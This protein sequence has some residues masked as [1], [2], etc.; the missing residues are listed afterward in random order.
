MVETK[1]YG[2]LAVTMILV[3]LFIVIVIAVMYAMAPK[4]GGALYW[5]QLGF[6]KL[7]G[8]GCP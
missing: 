2:A 6:C 4:G 7:T 3:L 5:V 8:F 1:Y